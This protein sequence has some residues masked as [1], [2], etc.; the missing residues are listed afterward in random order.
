VDGGVIDYR[1]R[2]FADRDGGLDFDLFERLLASTQRLVARAV[3]L[4]D[5]WLRG[6]DRDLDLLDGAAEQP[7]NNYRE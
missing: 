4:L 6:E 3:T 1:T 7:F 5:E 2:L